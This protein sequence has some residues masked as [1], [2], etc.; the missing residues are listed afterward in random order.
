MSAFPFFPLQGCLLS[1]KMCRCKTRLR[2]GCRKASR[3]PRWSSRSTK[4]R[5]CRYE[6]FARYT[7]IQQFSPSSFCPFPLVF[8]AHAMISSRSFLSL[9]LLALV[10]CEEPRTTDRQFTPELTKSAAL[11]KPASHAKAETPAAASA[12]MMGA[13]SR[14]RCRSD[15]RWASARQCPDRGRSSGDLAQDHLRCP[16]LVRDRR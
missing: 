16:G 14:H 15:S 1:P 9:L 10:G 8:G 11:G 12:D 3:S 5:R 4:R 7:D 2:S 6:H 13:A